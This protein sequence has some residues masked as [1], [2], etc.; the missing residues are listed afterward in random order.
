MPANNQDAM[1]NGHGRL[2]FADPTG[3][4]PELGFQ[5]GLATGC[6][7]PGSLMEDLTEPSVALVR[8]AGAA[9]A[10]GDVVARAHARPRGEC[11]GREPAHVRAD[12]GDDA[13]GAPLAHPGDRVE[14]V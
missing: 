1:T 5:V 2:L 8:L 4:V 7:R 9:F 14:A 11:G 13:L 3:E 10:A 12:L 6:G